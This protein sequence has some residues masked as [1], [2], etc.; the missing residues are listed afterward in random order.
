MALT[1]YVIMP[2]EDYQAICDAVREKRNETEVIKSGEIAGKIQGIEATPKLQNKVVRMTS[3]DDITIAPGEGYDAIGSVTLDNVLWKERMRATNTCYMFDNCASLTT[4]PLFDTSKADSMSYMFN[5]CTSLTTVPQFDTSN[6][7]I[8]SSMFW[9][10]SNLTECW[11]RNIKTSLQVGSG[12]SYGHLLTLESLIHLIQ[13]CRDTG[14]L[15]TLTVGS[16]NLKKLANVYVRTIEIT[17]EMRAED[18]YI[19]EKLPFEICE[20]TDEGAM[21]IVDYAVEKNWSIK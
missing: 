13:E 17:D 8:M 11:L 9:N 19:D 10:C 4:V 14:S 12:T 15:K 7:T 2:G 21:L 5:K 16:A 3:I 18:E 20:S 6:V 1:D